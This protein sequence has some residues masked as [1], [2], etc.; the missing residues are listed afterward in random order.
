MSGET[1]EEKVVSSISSFLYDNSEFLADAWQ[2][3]LEKENEECSGKWTKRSKGGR[4]G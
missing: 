1:I 2:L 4:G 3:P